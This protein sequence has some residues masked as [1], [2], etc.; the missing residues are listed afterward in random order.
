MKWY[1][2]SPENARVLGAPGEV[3]ELGALSLSL[4]SEWREGQLFML[5]TAYVDET[6]MDGPRVMLA[7]YISR[8]ADWHGF[9]NA[10]RKLLKASGNIPYSHITEMRKGEGPFRGWTDATLD[11]FIRGVGPIVAKYCSL[12]LTVAVDRAVH[13]EKYQANMPPKT[14]ADSAYGMCARIFFERI[15]EY[16]EQ[17]MGLRHARIN[18]VFERHDQ[19]FGDA[20]RI[21]NELKKVDPFFK[22]R[23]GTIT[24]GEAED[25]AGLQA[26]DALAFMARR[27]E[28]NQNFTVVPKDAPAHEVRQLTTSECLTFHVDINE[29]A[30]GEF[31]RI[32]EKIGHLSRRQR[33]KRVSERKRSA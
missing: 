11:K 16:V 19:H 26:A 29:G 17:Y 21:F 24:P 5:V 33:A 14:S 15:P 30:V 27:L 23:L 32:H 6:G 25:F 12:G 31:H 4:C 20:E 10:W 18:F 1:P 13:K 8:T 28:P 2:L 7:G 3:D 22:E 9:A